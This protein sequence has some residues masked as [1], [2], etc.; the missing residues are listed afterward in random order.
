MM[1]N[2][3]PYEDV[4]W[5]WSDQYD[6]NLQYAGFA[7]EW[8]DLKHFLAVARGGGKMLLL[9]QSRRDRDAR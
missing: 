7:M 8:D 2:G 6:Q 9:V 3:A 5:F 4:Y 1:G